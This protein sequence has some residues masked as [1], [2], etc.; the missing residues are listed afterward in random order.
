MAFRHAKNG[1]KSTQV[2]RTVCVELTA[3]SMGACSRR[4]ATRCPCIGF[5]VSHTGTQMPRQSELEEF[6][7]QIQSVAKDPEKFPP[8]RVIFSLIGAAAVLGVVIWA[9]VWLLVNQQ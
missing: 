7:S 8:L 1:K 4:F 3:F 6:E 5:D 9:V 2:T